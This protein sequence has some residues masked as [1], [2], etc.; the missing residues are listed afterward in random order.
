MQRLAGSCGRRHVPSR[1]QI[2]ANIEAASPAMPQTQPS[3]LPK[4]LKARLR[5]T[6]GPMSTCNKGGQLQAVAIQ[7]TSRGSF[8]FPSCLSKRQSVP[9]KQSNFRVSIPYRMLYLCALRNEWTLQAAAPQ[10][11]PVPTCRPCGIKFS[12]RQYHVEVPH[13]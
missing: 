11:A 8:C 1:T 5:C 4:Q 3:A 12:Y 2:N 9:Q 7:A 6:N 10:A 13:T